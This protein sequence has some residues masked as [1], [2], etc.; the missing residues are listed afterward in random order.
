VSLPKY[1]FGDY[2]L[3]LMKL[4]GD[5]VWYESMNRDEWIRFVTVRHRVG[6]NFVRLLGN[7]MKILF[8]KFF[9][10]FTQIF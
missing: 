7:F 8:L 2:E 6:K 10:N 5:D 1:R 9:G 3:N 4:I